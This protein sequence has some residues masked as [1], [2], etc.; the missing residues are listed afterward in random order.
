MMLT[1][2]QNIAARFR[3]HLRCDNCLREQAKTISVPEVDDAPT[4]VEELLE[5]AFIHQHW[6]TCHCGEVVTGLVAVT[7]LDLDE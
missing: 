6:A 5:S 1:A 3:L 4:D 7:K 2:H